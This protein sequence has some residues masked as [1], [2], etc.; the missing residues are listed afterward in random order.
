MGALVSAAPMSDDYDDADFEEEDFQESP[1]VNAL[2]RYEEI[3]FC[4]DCDVYMPYKVDGAIVRRQ[5]PNCKKQFEGGQEVTTTGAPVKAAP[6]SQSAASAG[7]TVAS[8]GAVQTEVLLCAATT[9]AGTP[10]QNPPRAGSK[11][12]SSHRGWR[13]PRT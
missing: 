11:Y 1:E 7:R 4:P 2:G 10:C 12:C 5:C 13:P 6:R 9:K 3:V 8:A